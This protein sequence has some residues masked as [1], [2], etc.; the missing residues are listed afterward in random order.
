MVKSSAVSFAA[1]K[2]LRSLQ[3]NREFKRI[4]GD[5]PAAMAN[6]LWEAMVILS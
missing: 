3:F 6:Q 5:A 4:F 1:L 2:A